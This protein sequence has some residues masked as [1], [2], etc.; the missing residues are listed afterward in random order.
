MTQQYPDWPGPRN[1]A[2]GETYARDDPD[3]DGNVFVVTAIED[4]DGVI[5]VTGR[6]ESQ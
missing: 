6:F 4:D 3:G 2:V 1:A 5:K